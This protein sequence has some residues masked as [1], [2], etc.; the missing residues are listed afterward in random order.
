MFNPTNRTYVCIRS[1]RER[2]ATPSGQK[3]GENPY[4]LCG[5]EISILPEAG[6]GGGKGGRGAGIQYLGPKQGRYYLPSVAAMSFMC[7]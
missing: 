6:D 7:R 5:S 4:E 1:I 3:I 2:C